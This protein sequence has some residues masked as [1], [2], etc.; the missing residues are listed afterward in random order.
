MRDLL[1]F[2]DDTTIEHHGP[3]RAHDHHA[4]QQVRGEADVVEIQVT[5]IALVLDEPL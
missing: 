1:S 2:G 3:R 5:A 4:P